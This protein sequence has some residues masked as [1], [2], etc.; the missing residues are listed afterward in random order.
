MTLSAEQA[1]DGM[2][3]GKRSYAADDV[4]TIILFPETQFLNVLQFK[5]I[6]WR[7]IFL[8]IPHFLS[9]DLI[10]EQNKDQNQ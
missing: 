4:K 10:N 3:K 7:N 9:V 8:N 2:R 5:N 1:V 6:Y